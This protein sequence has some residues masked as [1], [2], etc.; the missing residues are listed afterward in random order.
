MLVAV[1][2]MGFVGCSKD[3]GDDTVAIP[4]RPM[5]TM[6][7]TADAD[8]SSRTYYVEE[9]GKA[10]WESTG[11]KICVWE[12][13]D[14]AEATKAES[15]EAVLV[16]DKAIFE[17]QFEEAEGTEFAYYAVY[18][19]SAVVG[20]TTKNENLDVA[21]LKLM[22]PAVQSATDSSFDGDADLL[23]AQPK[24]FTEQPTEL[25][26]AFKRLVAVG[27]MTLKNLPTEEEILSVTFSSQDKVLAGR[28]HFDATTGEVV[29]YGYDVNNASDVLTI[30]FEGGL[31]NEKA[32][33][34]IFFTALP[35]E[36]A[37][38][39]SFTVTASTATQKFTRT[40]TLPAESSIAFNAGRVSSFS[41]NMASAEVEP[42]SSLEGEYAVMALAE[43]KLQLMGNVSTTSTTYLLRTEGALAT[44]V[45]AT[46]DTNDQSL[47]WIVEKAATEGQY[48]LKQKSTSKYVAW[49]S[50]NSAKLQEA[51]YALTIVKQDDGSYDVISVKDT[52]RKLVYN[53]SSPRFAFYASTQTAIYLV[54]VKE[55]TD[56]MLSV[57][58]QPETVAAEGAEVAVELS[59]ANLTEEIG[60]AVDYAEGE[61]WIT[62]AT[63]ADNTLT[64]T[65][66]ENTTEEER[67][68][69]ITLSANGVEATVTV[70]QS[71]K[72]PVG[73]PKWVK[74][75]SL[76]ELAVGDRVALVG[77]VSAT[78]YS[79]K[80]NGTSSAPTAVSVTIENGAIAESSISAITTFNIGVSG[81]NYI[82]YE[83]ETTTKWLYCTNTN[84]GV[85][86]GT[87]T[88][89]T[90]V[91]TK[92]TN[93]GSNFEFKHVGTSRYLGIY[94]KADWR[95]YTT[96][97]AENFTNGS[98]T[99][100]IAIY[101]LSEA[102]GDIDTPV[103]PEQLA[104]PT[105]VK[106]TA[107][108]KMVTVTW[109]EVANADS[110][111]ITCGD[112]TEDY[113]EG[114]R[115]EF[116]MEYGKT[117]NVTVVANAAEGSNYTTSEAAT[118]TVTTEA[119]PNTGGGEAVTA[120]LTNAEIAAVTTSNSY[121]EVTISSNSGTW[122][123]KAVV[124]SN[125]LQINSPNSSSRKGSHVKSP[126]FSGVISKIVIYTTNNT[127]SGTMAY[128]CAANY[129]N[130]MT[131]TGVPSNSNILT[132]GATSQ[133]NGTI[134]I[135]NMESL[136][137]SQ[138]K[139][140]AS[141]ALYIDHIEVTYQ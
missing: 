76:S 133:A 139:I 84:N 63:I 15:A 90:W 74:I 56:P 124:G 97:Y 23:I 35:C 116:E 129:D 80:T 102:T 6:T 47:I 1:A 12:S 130:G 24:S 51:G 50:G 71:G 58:A 49:E 108:G 89:K 36:I 138:F 113:V 131:S 67:N 34:P 5:V 69:T 30:N 125:F 53:S 8:D 115:V 95:C 16:D 68:A 10:Q 77:T 99:S 11:E 112:K 136:N 62:G 43:G 91:I 13:I 83:A 18:P 21:K 127:Q 46:Y 105:N 137:L 122:T 132:S 87:N 70:K 93:K 123:A 81:T 121:K 9:D 40:V 26:L 48:Y 103:E 98:G 22:T 110:Y 107:S 118:T 65:V 28:S 117:Y 14:A 27:K 41:V 120:T 114:T 7:I 141:K 33:T 88:D 101:K 104:T 128:I 44:A 126:V 60:I 61:G 2:A 25:S 20:L 85:R 78:N 66:A 73:T 19:S 45:P 38:E 140:F 109:S 134:T 135:D 42:I 100:D 96:V 39:E 52:T 106:A 119:D 72:A 4:E 55:N 75:T 86:S 29:K 31:A 17:V 79:L 57:I 3:Q 92:H 37:G 54:P 64:F 32:G 59:M 111:T 94:N 82:L